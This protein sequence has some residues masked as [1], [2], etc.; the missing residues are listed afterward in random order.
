MTL[1]ET[2]QAAQYAL[3][4]GEFDRAAS[5]AK[6]ALEMGG[7]DAELDEAHRIVEWTKDKVGTQSPAKVS[8]LQRVTVVDVDISFGSM[9][10]L[11][12]K[13]S[14]A[15]IPAAIIVFLIWLLVGFVFSPVWMR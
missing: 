4:E 2:I 11:L 10:W 7:N 8:E 5:L 15:A 3:K 14:F 1:S 6:Q 9:V 13:L 12:I